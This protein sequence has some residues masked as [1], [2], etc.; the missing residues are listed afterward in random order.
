MY[1]ATLVSKVEN[2]DLEGNVD[3]RIFTGRW[4]KPG[5]LAPYKALGKVYVASSDELA[6]PTTY[7][8]SRSKKQRTDD[9]FPSV[10][11]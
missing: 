9:L 6:S 3:R 8:T 10:V 4:R 11:L 2:A 5:D 7:A 1:N